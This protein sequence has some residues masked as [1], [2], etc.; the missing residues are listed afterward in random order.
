MRCP[1]CSFEG[2]LVDGACAGCGYRRL[3]ISGDSFSVDSVSRRYSLSS[4]PAAS[5]ASRP[6]TVQRVKRGDVLRQGRY[7][8]IEQLTLPENQQGQ[9]TAWLATD[10]QLPQGRV[11]IREVILP[12]EIPETKKQMVRSIALRLSELAQHPGFPRVLDVFSEQ[13]DY[14]IVFQ[15][16]EGESLATLLRRQGGALPE[17]TVAEYG[18]QL[19]EMLSILSRQEMPIV[20]G[21]ISPETIIVSPDRSR[22]WLIHLPILPPKEPVTSNVPS[23][24]RAP[25]QARGNIGPSSDL[26][27]VAA[28]L[29]YAVTG[30]DPS[31]R[32]A[33]FHPPAR[34]LNPT[35]TPGMEAILSRQLRLSP[36]QRY[37]RPSEMQ[38][39]LSALLA[40]YGPVSDKLVTPAADPIRLDAMQMRQRSRNR[41]LLDVGI[42]AGVGIMVLFAFLLINLRPFSGTATT[43]GSPTPNVT[44]TTLAQ[45]QALNAELALE[46]KTFQ[47]KGIGISDGRFAFDVY[48]GRNDSNE[49]KQ[50]ALAIQH[51][52]LSSAVE[53]LRKAI[54]EDPTD[55]EAQIY[56]EDLHLLQTGAP[57]V[58][59]VLGLPIDSSDADL[60]I[61]RNNMESA[62]LIQHKMNE[63]NLLPHGLKLR[64]LIDSSG[65]NDGDVATVAQFIA[66]RVANVGNLDHII[67]VVGWPFSTQTINARDI[68]ASVHLPL[69]SQTAS[70]VKLS[71]S[72]PYFFRVNPPDDL[73][74]KTLGNVAVNQLGAKTILVLRD[75]TDSYSVSLADA[76]IANVRA[77]KAT[78][79]NNPGDY[80]SET[81]TTVQQYQKVV[82]D[83]ITNKADL[84]FIAGLDVDAVRLAVAVGNA[85][86][87]NPISTYLKNLR[88]MGGDA[89][90]TG[91]LLGQ[92]NGPDAQLAVKFPQDM[93]R[94]IFTAFGH[95]DEWTFLKVPQSQQPSFFVDWANTYQSSTVTAP[96]PA[97]GN[98][99]MLTYDA[100]GV[101]IRA[102]SLANGTVTGQAVRAALASLGTGKIPAFQGVS[103]RILFDG[104]G[105]PVEKAIVVLEVKNSNGANQIALLQIAGRFN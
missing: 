62:F 78:A 2:D 28:T 73:Q 57:Y 36:Q 59:I 10:S 27:A 92:G 63:G 104:N 77:D 18:R 76:F 25:E 9:G 47:Q 32:M 87:A 55:G 34:R 98:D 89:L 101:I 86:R 95:P 19:C 1:R 70:S 99:A 60:S 49:K 30:F 24:Y 38:K 33:F 17:R 29:H 102:A 67:A 51:G 46:L 65:A 90:D 6:L 64:I 80:F 48:Q 54:T 35:V 74:G 7:H 4:T 50:A 68:I 75:Q 82:A 39:D 40:S 94:L 41:T 3:N 42:F 31:E 81:N 83:A 16:I 45:Q 58:T 100:F 26:Y 72:S 79:I 21:S 37:A 71:H 20:L 66:K 44:A 53:L 13:D 23:G 97:P 88:I 43:S 91:L 22:V 8:L 52:D 61:D 11:V 5:S 12:G 96:A 69:V 84:I 93:Q 85:Y 56:N 103:G 14:F 15:R 105:N